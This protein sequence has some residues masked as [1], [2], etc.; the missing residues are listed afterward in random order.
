[1]GSGK[2]T[3][4]R[5]VARRTNRPFVDSDAQVESRTGRTVREIFEQDGEPAFRALEAEALAEA[6]ATEEPAVIAAAGGVV[7]SADNRDL[8]KRAGRVVWLRA[9]TGTLAHRVKHGDHRPLLADDAVAVL[10]RLADERRPLYE[11]VADVVIDVDRRDKRDIV[12]EVEALV[13]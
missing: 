2:T 13:P 1:M 10:K 9:R 3:V 5:A 6:L 7:L 4:G 11:E 12:A 8:L